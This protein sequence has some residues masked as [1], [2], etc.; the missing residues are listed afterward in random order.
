MPATSSAASG[1]ARLAPEVTAV[2]MT[3]EVVVCCSPSVWPNS[4]TRV[5]KNSS[6]QLGILL[7]S[8][9]SSSVECVIGTNVGLP[10]GGAAVMLGPPSAS[11]PGGTSSENSTSMLGVAP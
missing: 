9:H 10:L 1:C 6:C 3:L 8:R 2:D 11:N 5:V 4:C 7:I